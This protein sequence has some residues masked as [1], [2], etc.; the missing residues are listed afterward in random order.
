MREIRLRLSGFVLLSSL[1][2]GSAWIAFHA[3]WKLQE[4]GQGVWRIVWPG[5]LFGVLMG[6]FTYLNRRS[7]GF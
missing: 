6:Y 3:L 5:L 2:C 7:D 1:F 4:T